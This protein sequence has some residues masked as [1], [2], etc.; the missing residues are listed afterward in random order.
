VR[1]SSPR[2]HECNVPHDQSRQHDREA[3]ANSQQQASALHYPA[4]FTA[5]KNDWRLRTVDQVA[6]QMD[7]RLMF[8]AGFASAKKVSKRDLCLSSTRGEIC[9]VQDKNAFI[10]IATQQP[11]VAVLAF[12]NLSLIIGHF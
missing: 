8:G 5:S 7:E 4:A 3:D 11:A 2:Q 1:A 12:I 10:I 6:D 9:F